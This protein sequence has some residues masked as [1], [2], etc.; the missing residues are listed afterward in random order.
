MKKIKNRQRWVKETLSRWGP[1][2]TPH[3]T[4]AAS[5]SDTKGKLLPGRRGELRVPTLSKPALVMAVTLMW[6]DIRT[7]C[8]PPSIAEE[9]LCVGTLVLNEVDQPKKWEQNQQN[10]VAFTFRTISYEEQTLADSWTSHQ[11]GRVTKSV[12][13][14]SMAYLFH[15]LKHLLH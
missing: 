15:E 12:Y 8:P 14:N 3:P 9:A 1:D 11:T 6:W 2:V 10:S 13:T 4:P 7:N 5:R